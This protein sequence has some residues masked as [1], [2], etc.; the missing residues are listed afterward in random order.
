VA[1]EA[2]REQLEQLKLKVLKGHV[3]QL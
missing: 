3:T 2:A 1:G